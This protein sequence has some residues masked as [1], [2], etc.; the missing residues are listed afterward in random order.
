MR[1]V[2]ESAFTGSEIQIR[3]EVRRCDIG[4]DHATRVAGNAKYERA[5][6]LVPENGY[7]FRTT[8]TRSGSVAVVVAGLGA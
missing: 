7:Q 2:L 1:T 8:P 4:S 5:G 6:T 3:I